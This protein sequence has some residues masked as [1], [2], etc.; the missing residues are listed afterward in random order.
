MS[1]T[2]PALGDGC[3]VYKYNYNRT[4]SGLIRML[5]PSVITEGTN[6]MKRTD[7]SKEALG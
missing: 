3:A 4:P 5:I 1:Q 6:E 7:C 2:A